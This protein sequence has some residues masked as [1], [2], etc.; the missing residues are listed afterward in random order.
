M[1]PIVPSK[2]DHVQTVISLA[3]ITFA[4]ITVVLINLA[5]VVLS[6]VSSRLLTYY[7]RVAIWVLVCPITCQEMVDTLRSRMSTNLA[8]AATGSSAATTTVHPQFVTK[9]SILASLIIALL[10]RC[11]V[12]NLSG[13]AEDNLLGPAF[14]TD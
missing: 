14:R 4:Y 13:Q 12:F 7:T 5:P 6:E 9:S 8:P 10:L 2:L 11:D 1:P 3:N